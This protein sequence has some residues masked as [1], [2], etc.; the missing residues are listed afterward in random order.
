MELLLIM[1]AGKMLM[2]PSMEGVM[3]QAQWVRV[4]R[5]GFKI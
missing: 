5:G 2:P 1:E 4:F 3:H